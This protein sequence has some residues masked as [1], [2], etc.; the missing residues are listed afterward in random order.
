MRPATGARMLE[1]LE[2]LLTADLSVPAGL[3][4]FCSDPEQWMLL[5]WSDQR[6]EKYLDSGKCIHH[7]FQEQASKVPSQTAI[8]EDS[9]SLTY[10]QLAAEAG[11]VA[12]ELLATGVTT[13]SLVPLMSQRCLEMVIAIFGILFAGGG[14]VP[15][16]TKW[17]D[18][19]VLEVITQCEPRAACAGP[20]FA[21][22]LKSI[23]QMEPTNACCVLDMRLKRFSCAENMFQV[24]ASV[25]PKVRTCDAGT[26]QKGAHPWASK[27][28]KTTGI[29]DFGLK[30][31]IM[32]FPKSGRPQYLPQAVGRVLQGHPQKDPSLQ[33]QPSTQQC[34]LL[35][36]QS[37]FGMYMFIL[38]AQMRRARGSQGTRAASCLG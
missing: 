19:R 21:E 32:E 23:V 36:P 37:L 27:P 5:Q 28:R 3:L 30:D 9:K 26:L 7:F 12:L 20:G 22:R 14:Y 2:V 35:P 29:K 8:I 1:H 11:Q 34:L 15:L 6:S 24:L 13:D 31:H 25:T 10:A 17:P 4:Q 38:Y 18:D 16:D 33:K